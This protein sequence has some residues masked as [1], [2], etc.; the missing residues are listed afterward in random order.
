[1]S[2]R[3]LAGLVFDVMLTVAFIFVFAAIVIGIGS[4]R[5]AQ[6]RMRLLWLL[7]VTIQ[8]L[9]QRHLHRLHKMRSRLCFTMCPWMP[10]CRNSS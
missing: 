7:Q 6:R 2:I 8:P 5:L 9:Q 4:L 10:I 3:R 1:M